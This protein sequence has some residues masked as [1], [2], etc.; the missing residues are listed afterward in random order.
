M[1]PSE[2]KEGGVIPI[3]RSAPLEPPKNFGM[4]PMLGRAPSSPQVAESEAPIDAEAAKKEFMSR[5]GVSHE[6]PDGPPEVGPAEEAPQPAGPQVV[7]LDPMML[8]RI[9]LLGAKQKL[10]ERDAQ[11]A[12]IALQEAERRRSGFAREEQALMAEVGGQLGRP[13]KG[14]IRLIDKEK[15]LCQVE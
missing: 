4:P 8:M 6:A 7:Q 2:K 10:A 9:E 3:P 14:N 15:G 11:L 12:R 5:A 13:I 1:E